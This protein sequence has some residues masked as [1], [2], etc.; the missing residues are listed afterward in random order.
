MRVCNL[1]EYKDE[2]VIAFIG[3]GFKVRPFQRRGFDSNT[4]MHSLA[5]DGFVESLRQNNFGRRGTL[6]ELIPCRRMLS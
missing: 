3:E 5:R 1:V 2:S 6:R 4:L